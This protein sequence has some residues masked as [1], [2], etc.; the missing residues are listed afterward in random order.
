MSTKNVSVNFNVTVDASGN[1]SVFSQPS[2]TLQDTIV[3]TVPLPKSTL[4]KGADNSLIKF[5]D[6]AGNVN[7]I[8]A[9]LD[10]VFTAT[11]LNKT[12][13]T[14]GFNAIING[15]FDCSGAAPFSSYLSTPSYYTRS[16]FGQVALGKYAH[17]LFGHVAATAAIDNDTG[18]VD[19]MN[20]NLDGQTPVHA[21]IATLLTNAIYLLDATKCTAIAKQVIGQDSSRAGLPG[22]GEDNDRAT[23]AGFQALE[24]K[25]GDTIYV[26]VKLLAPTVTVTSGQQSTPVSTAERTYALKINLNGL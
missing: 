2:T 9:E 24:F 21:K 3:A 10:T 16:N 14:T 13:M 12:A 8:H 22:T 20:G 5:Q 6:A 19:A 1:V 25:G 7:D 17:D 18:F 23:P 26:Q 11:A 15:Q 4:Y